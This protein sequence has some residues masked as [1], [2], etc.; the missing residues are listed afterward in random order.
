MITRE[1]CTKVGEVSKTHGLQGEVVVTT[2]SD[3]LER[4][5]D[6]PVFLQLD[7]APVPFFIADEGLSVRNH[8]SYIVKFDYVDTL[9]QAERLTGCEVMLEN[10]LLGEEEADELDFDVFGLVDFVVTDELSGATGIV[11]DVA[12]YSGNVV[13]TISIF[14]KEVLLPLS[15]VYILGIDF[16]K[17]QLQVRISA[18]LAELN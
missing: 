14:G 10:A 11:T 8:T 6:E 9:E 15:E 1:D 17:Q 13:L 16:E 12:D 3:L 4:Y 18:E 5:A 7:G 2:D